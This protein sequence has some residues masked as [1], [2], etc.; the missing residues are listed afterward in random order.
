MIKSF[1]QRIT[2]FSNI[3]FQN[4]MKLLCLSIPNFELIIFAGLIL[5]PIA[6]ISPGPNSTPM[7]FEPSLKSDM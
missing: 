6:L 7:S 4:S 5:P 2:R 1:K 3:I